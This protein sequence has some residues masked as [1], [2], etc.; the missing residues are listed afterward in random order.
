MQN[1][2]AV[3]EELG[4]AIIQGYLS[5]KNVGG[6]KEEIIRLGPVLNKSIVG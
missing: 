3:L 6:A 1:I 4:L 2:S 5:R